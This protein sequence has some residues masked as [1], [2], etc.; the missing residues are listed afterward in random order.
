MFPRTILKFQARWSFF[1]TKSLFFRRCVTQVLIAHVGPK[2]RHFC[3]YSV[4]FRKSLPKLKMDQELF[5][6]SFRGLTT[7]NC[8]QKPDYTSLN[9]RELSSKENESSAFAFL[10][11]P[12]Y[13]DRKSCEKVRSG[14]AEYTLNEDGYMNIQDLVDFL[15]RENAMDIC[16]IRTT[17]DKRNYVDYF[18]VVSGVSSRHLRA[19]AKNLEQLFRGHEVRGIGRDGHVVVEGLESDH[20][21]ALDIG[22]I[23]VHFFLP[24]V[25]DVYELE[26]LWTLGPKIDD[27][28]K[29][30]LEYES[31]LQATE[32][33]ISLD[34]DSS[35]TD[36]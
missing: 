23:V 1:L 2:P 24:E 32:F 9:Q 18:V 25:R 12:E 3:Q 28:S 15:K 16:V 4:W 26:K 29:A 14:F 8:H 33:G 5:I 31:F 6:F 21:V 34:K 10:S 19:M 36:G 35:I 22:N 11:G 27:Q 13:I 20:W 7:R 30:I 17:G